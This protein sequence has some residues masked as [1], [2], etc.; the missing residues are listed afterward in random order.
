MKH[1]ENNLSK[2]MLMG[3]P[4]GAT[5]LGPEI[6]PKGLIISP[7]LFSAPGLNPFPIVPGYQ[8]LYVEKC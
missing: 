3:I 1:P 7:R 6:T 2:Q 4:R 8:S 5:E